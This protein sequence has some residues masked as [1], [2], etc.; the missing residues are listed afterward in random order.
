[1]MFTVCATATALCL[2]A[3]ERQR[4]GGNE[5]AFAHALTSLC[6]PG[7]TK[8]D[9]ERHYR[10]LNARDPEIGLRLALM[11]PWLATGEAW[12]RIYSQ[13]TAGTGG[14]FTPP[15]SGGPLEYLTITDFKI[16]ST[17]F[18]FRAEW[19]VT[20]EFPADALD[21]LFNLDLDPIYWAPILWEV[22]VTQHLLMKDFE[23]PFD[24][25]YLHV[26]G[27]PPPVGFF[28]IRPSYIWDGED[29][30]YIRDTW[31]QDDSG[32]P[33]EIFPIP[34]LSP[35]YELLSK[36]TVMLMNNGSQMTTLSQT[37]P[38][39]PG[40]RHLI[41]VQCLDN[42]VGD[43]FLPPRKNSFSWTI[44]APGS[45]AM[46]GATETDWF[47]T[48]YK[49]QDFWFIS[50]PTNAT[51]PEI[52]VSAAIL[53]PSP[54][55]SNFTSRI[56]VDVV[57]VW[58]ATSSIPEV[59]LR[60]PPGSTDNAGNS[61]LYH[62]PEGGTA[63]ITGTPSRPQVSPYF[64]H[65]SSGYYGAN[66]DG[67]N[68]AYRLT[69]ETE[70]PGYRSV[71]SLGRDPD[72][73]QYPTNGLYTAYSNI[74]PGYN[75]SEMGN[76]EIIGGKCTLYCKIKDVKGKEMEQQFNFFIRG[77][78]PPD[79]LAKVYIDD[80]MPA[81]CKPYAWAII[82]HESKTKSGYVYNQFNPAGPTIHLPNK[83]DDLK[84]GTKQWGWGMCQ[85]D[86]GA[87]DDPKN[88]N[89]V[90]TAEVYN[91]RTNVLSAAKIFNE[92]LATHNKLINDFKR[93]YPNCGNP[94]GSTNILG[95][96]M[97]AERFGVTV[98]YN[99]A[100]GV[101]A[102]RIKTA[103][104][105]PITGNNVYTNI[106]SPVS[107]NVGGNQNWSFHDNKNKYAERIAQEIQS[108]QTIKE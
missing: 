28:R 105:N 79:A 49:Y 58:L 20:Q 25:F 47:G 95:V 24:A 34:P 18:L 51:S 31:D 65:S 70:R 40:M 90:S 50:I 76:N 7:A 37:I 88:T 9:F 43:I 11:L 36:K 61:Q 2:A 42:S 63:F 100:G 71:S 59:A 6:A 81:F 96:T 38:T 33:P 98:L 68:V 15:R 93:T 35:P 10:R 45:P 78:N 21:V 66:G 67:L 89:Y 16:G 13:R 5:A 91:W 30:G 12:D 23:V 92:K 56:Y 97:N 86:K 62:L 26:D 106:W 72:Y 75:V 19:P 41:V 46:T 54:P 4:S 29:E 32:D 101:P 82:R 57:S 53:P 1:M 55:T 84:N 64:Q 48:I 80:V 3:A 87:L 107:F 104:I 74:F 52:Q 8:D 69:I 17:S 27:V 22:P 99:G 108:T 44:T 103:Q 73:R 14:I 60:T 83:T 77:L 94:I 85:I 102:S 39:A